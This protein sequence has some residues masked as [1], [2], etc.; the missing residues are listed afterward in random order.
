MLD[1]SKDIYPFSEIEKK[2]KGSGLSYA[3]L[4]RFKDYVE[5]E[6]GGGGVSKCHPVGFVQGNLAY[7]HLKL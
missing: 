7:H 4:L 2:I 6:K 5:S 3:D 1:K